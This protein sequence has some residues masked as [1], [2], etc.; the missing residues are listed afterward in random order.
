MEKLLIAVVVLLAILVVG[1]LV[2]VV[3]FLSKLIKMKEKPVS[4]SSNDISPEVMDAIEQANQTKNNVPSQFCIDHPELPAKGM[5][6][7]S[8]EVYCELCLTKED[9]VKLARKHLDLWLDSDWEDIYMVSNE[10]TGADKLNELIRKKKEIW[11]SQ[12]IPMV[13]QKQFKIN[14]ENDRI[15]AYTMVKARV[16]D[17]DLIKT[18]FDFLNS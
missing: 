12:S 16:E 1:L 13:T 10:L 5:C 14:I 15:E 7:I 4:E 11:L 2:V 3:I 18:N 17:R 9:D 6:S 8:N